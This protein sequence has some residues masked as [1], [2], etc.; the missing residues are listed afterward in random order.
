VD[1]IECDLRVDQDRRGARMNPCSNARAIAQ[2]V[3][4]AAPY[5]AQGLVRVIMI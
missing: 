4:H 3:T 2:M 5:Y 1:G